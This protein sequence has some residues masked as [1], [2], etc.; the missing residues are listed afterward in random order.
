VSTKP[1]EPAAV[2]ETRRRQC[3]KPGRHRTGALSLD[4]T[5]LPVSG[6]IFVPV[7]NLKILVSTALLVERTTY[8]DRIIEHVRTSADHPSGVLRPSSRPAG[9]AGVGW[10]PTSR[11]PAEA[12][13]T[14]LSTAT[15]I[16]HHVTSYRADDHRDRPLLHSLTT[17]SRR[18]QPPPGPRRRVPAAAPARRRAAA[19]RPAGR[20]IGDMTICRGDPACSYQVTGSACRDRVD[21]PVFHSRSSRSTAGARAGNRARSAPIATWSSSLASWAPRQ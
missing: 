16:K 8:I 18:G 5:A 1:P 12:A 9:N 3:L 20:A 17:P 6:L 15:G 2:A 4:I 13:K 11:P 19:Q 14:L 10:S 7:T 21:S